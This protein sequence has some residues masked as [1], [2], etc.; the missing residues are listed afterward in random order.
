MFP[1][2][3]SQR[4]VSC[5]VWGPDYHSVLKQGKSW[6]IMLCHVRKRRR[7]VFAAPWR[8]LLIRELLVSSKLLAQGA[9]KSREHASNN[10]S[11]IG[12][13]WFREP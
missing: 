13:R 7:A 1:R 8:E 2:G 10:F 6:V 4:P 5:G 9:E 3:L 11:E 12:S